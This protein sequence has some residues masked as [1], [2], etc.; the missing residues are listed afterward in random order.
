[1]VIAEVIVMEAVLGVKILPR[2]AEVSLYP[3]DDNANLNRGG[4][5]QGDS[6]NLCGHHLGKSGPASLPLTKYDERHPEV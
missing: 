1:M 6:E 3:L 4:Y 5:R 2:E